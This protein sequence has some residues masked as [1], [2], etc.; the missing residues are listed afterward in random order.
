MQRSPYLL[1]ALA[2]SLAAALP[3]TAREVAPGSEDMQTVI[4]SEAEALIKQ[5]RTDAISI[6]VV[7]DG[8]ATFYNFG[9]ISRDKPQ[10]PTKDT[11][12]EIGSISKTFGSLLLAQSIVAGKA[13]PG[14]E[15]RQFL[16]GDYSNLAFEGKPVRL[17]DLVTTTS[18]LPDN[19]P[20]FSALAKDVPPD[21]I[22]LKIAQALNAYSQATLLKDLQSVSLATAPGSTPKHSNLAAELVGVSVAKIE[23]KPF[24]Q[25]LATRIEKPFG[26]QSGIGNSRKALMATGYKDGGAVAPA[27]DA[28]VILAAGGL[29][30]SAA[31]MARYITAQLK[32][33]NAAID[34]THQPAWRSD[35]KTIGY[36][37]VINT[38]MDGETRLS[39]TGGTFGF[40][41][42]IDLYPDADYGI[43]F[44]T[45]RS[46]GM[47][48]GQLWQMSDNIM[49]RV[50]G[51]SP[52]FSALKTTLDKVGYAHVSDTVA[53][54]R[55]TWP[56][57]TLSEDDVNLWGYAL[58]KQ[59]RTPEALAILVYNTEQHPKSG[60]AFDSLGEARRAAG[61]IPQSIRDFRTSLELNPQNENA[62]KQI[63]EMEAA[64]GK[65]S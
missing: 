50:W 15:L 53:Q 13:K 64:D 2:F 10:A 23:G 52:G 7:R 16:P 29:H 57:L 9:T 47:L 56:K 19:L 30:Y 34:L 49:R 22:S 28:P 20:D 3:A 17:I 48:Q 21:Q 65:K 1:T 60:N 61:D 24:D 43:V 37:W 41:S 32:G 36:N 4:R 40:S 59:K 46:S 38:T 33:G 5:G 25:L 42:L 54:V 6:A 44:L 51:E 45:N 63:A 62:R 26:M 14:D 31:D 55:K 39:H 12:Y 27:L 18:G 8:K 58:L 35:N 11:V